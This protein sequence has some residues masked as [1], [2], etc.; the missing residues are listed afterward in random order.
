MSENTSTTSDQRT[1]RRPPLPA[2]DGP[3]FKAAFEQSSV[4]RPWTLGYRSMPRERLST[5]ELRISGRIPPG[6][7]GVFYRNGPALH[8]RGG[9]RYGHRW[10]GDGMVQAFRLRDGSISHRGAMVRTEKFERE[11]QAGRM[12][13]ST[14]GTHVPGSDAVP[15]RMDDL[16]SAN[17]GVIRVG[18]EL[19]ALWEPGSAYV[20]DPLSLETHGR[21]TWLAATMGAPF[22][23][24]PRREPDGSL[25]NFGVDPLAGCL[26]VYRIDAGG[27][28]RRHRRLQF[29]ALPPVHDFAITERHLV[30]VLPS[31]RVSP[32]RLHAGVS[33][34]EACA[35]R[36]DVAMEVLAIDKDDFS[37][38]RWEMP[39]GYIFHIG[40]AWEDRQGVIRL[41]MMRADGPHSLLSGWSVMRGEYRHMGGASFTLVE[42]HPDATVR[43][44]VLPDPEGEFPVVDPSEV[45]RRYGRVLF[46]GRSAERPSDLVGFDE[47]VLADVD[48][49]A[50][51]RFRYGHDWLVEEHLL[52][53]DGS[54]PGCPA[55]WIIG[56][57]L[58][59]QQ[60]VSVVS[61]FDA[62]SLE[63]GPVAQCWLPYALPLG[64]HGR[65]EPDT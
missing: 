31:L 32:E 4:T 42:L 12:L 18:R 24:H 57:A 35:W 53:P 50:V 30:F 46:I 5:D 14:F 10:D 49:M 6:L 43:Q 61:V 54:D 47:V 60:K 1:M 21:K 19:L 16:N 25:W 34:A 62:R 38:R 36:P 23:A 8:E 2:W 55:R 63:S 29:P 44:V 13:V 48:S 64:L 17:I 39:A 41:D 11:E 28:L 9:A 20:L 65:F 59:L 7:R 15:A 56:T 3:A 45:G 51:Q 27:T 52:V 22:S 40:N 26:H 58:D 37:I 33:F